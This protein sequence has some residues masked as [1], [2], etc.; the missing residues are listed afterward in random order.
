MSEL[1]STLLQVITHEKPQRRAGKTVPLML[2]F[3]VNPE[4]SPFL[5]SSSRGLL[6]VGA[7]EGRVRAATR[8]VENLTDY[9]LEVVQ[10]VAEIGQREK[11]E[12]VYPLTKAGIQ[13][14]IDHLNFYD[15]KEL[16]ILAHPETEWGKIESEWGAQEGNKTV[17]LALLGLPLQPAPWLPPNTVLVIPRDRQYVGFVLLYQELICSV[18]HNASRGIGI[19]TTW[20]GSPDTCISGSPKP[21]K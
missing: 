1:A 3:P 20:D 9:F 18:I 15:L 6:W 5:V 8:K 10:E 12:N 21:S 13:G 7:H 14:A 11:W 17:P 19:A 16:E 4:L 2:E